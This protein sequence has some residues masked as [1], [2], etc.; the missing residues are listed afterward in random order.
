MLRVT[1]SPF[2]RPISPVLGLCICVSWLH[3]M[4]LVFLVSRICCS[5]NQEEQVSMVAVAADPRIRE[6]EGVVFLQLARVRMLG[7]FFGEGWG[8]GAGDPSAIL[9]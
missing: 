2:F 8:R 9:V 4:T 1:T 7:F 6:W 5:G 3:A